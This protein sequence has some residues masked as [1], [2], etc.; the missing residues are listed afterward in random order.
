MIWILSLKLLFFSV[1]CLAL[2]IWFR[3]GAGKLGMEE[4]VLA[5]AWQ[6]FVE[7]EV[8]LVGLKIL[9]SI[10][11]NEEM[12]VERKDTQLQHDLCVNAE[13]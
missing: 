4:D 7:T 12:E 6:S 13:T 10:R 5:C 9:S 3:G 1:R 11:P 2:W 8:F